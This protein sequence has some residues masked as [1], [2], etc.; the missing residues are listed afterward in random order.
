MLRFRN[1]YMYIGTFLVVL[2]YLATD[3]DSGFIESLP[4]GA[5]TLAMLV[6][7]LKAIMY[8]TI[9]HLSRKALF[10]YPEADFQKLARQAMAT[11]QGAGSFAIAMAV[12]MLAV[13]LLIFAA[14]Q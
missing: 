5:S 9:L 1:L 14:V 11:S 3:P 4:F 6:I 2:L 7:T 10:D 12:V 8:V 13:S